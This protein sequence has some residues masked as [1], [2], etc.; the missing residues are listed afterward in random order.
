MT[1]SIDW[2]NTNI[3]EIQRSDM[4]EIESNLY[5][6]NVDD[7]RKSLRSLEQSEEG[8]SFPKTHIHNT[9]ASVAGV[10]YARLVQIINPYSVRFEDGQYSVRLSGANNNIFDVTGGTLVRNQ[11]QVISNNSA[12]LIS[13]SSTLSEEDLSKIAQKVWN[14]VL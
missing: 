6:L 7:F 5:E 4:L 8:I 3:I 11:V 1:I 13:L 12:G 14:E 9:E 2:G 10:T